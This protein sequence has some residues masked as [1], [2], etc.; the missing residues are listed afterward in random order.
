[1]Y[2]GYVIVIVVFNCY[3]GVLFNDVDIGVFDEVCVDCLYY[4]VRVF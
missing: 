1:M 4:I 2:F 3:F